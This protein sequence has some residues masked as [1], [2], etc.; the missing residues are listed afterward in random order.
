M[1]VSFLI[2]CVFRVKHKCLLAP[3]NSPN[4][5]YLVHLQGH[6]LALL[7]EGLQFCTF[8]LKPYCFASADKPGLSM[9]R[10]DEAAQG[11]YAVGIAG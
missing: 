6:K 1:H 10:V 8:G 9:T 3:H 2:Q 4:T 5:V 7:L 11:V